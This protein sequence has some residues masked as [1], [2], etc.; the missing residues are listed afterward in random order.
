M[1]L[2]YPYKIF[3]IKE[4]LSND[5]LIYLDKLVEQFNVSK[6]EGQLD[7]LLWNNEIEDKFKL[8]YP[9]EYNR[10]K[11]TKI[12]TYDDFKLMVD[13]NE[14]IKHVEKK[15][16]NFR[17]S[18]DIDDHESIYEMY[19]K[20]FRL[21]CEKIY[22]KDI[23]NHNNIKRIPNRI[24]VYPNG[25]FLLKHRDGVEDGQRI[26]TMLFFINKNW[27]K[28]DGS[29]FKLYD[30]NE[31]FIEVIPNYEN[32]VIIEHTNFNLIHE[33]TKNL[34]DKMRYSI[35]CPFTINDYNTIFS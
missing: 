35:F 4:F 23:K 17:L 34:S 6:L 12:Y 15:Y 10:I 18:S 11:S 19:D 3:N 14:E 32:V 22:N 33:V 20:I 13:L 1:F 16:F 28:G 31:T 27:D 26:F 21:V 9:T 2:D 29:L 24:N 7:L 30:E 8:S 5:E 25:S